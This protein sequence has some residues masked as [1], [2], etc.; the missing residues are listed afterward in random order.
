MTV[1][2]QW[3]FCPDLKKKKKKWTYGAQALP[4]EI[5]Q[6]KTIKNTLLSRDWAGRS[7]LELQGEPLP[8]LCRIDSTDPIQS[9]QGRL[10]GAVTAQPGVWSSAEASGGCS[11][12]PSEQPGCG[13]LEE[14]TVPHLWPRRTAASCA[15]PWRGTVGGQVRCDLLTLHW[16]SQEEVEW[17]KKMGMQEGFVL[18]PAA[19]RDTAGHLASHRRSKVASA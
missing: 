14:S 19:W 11:R 4:M 9:A 5:L 8:G 16:V 13:E 10:C 6:S 12:V 18:Q 2:R 7:D 3:E 15:W 1:W 17:T